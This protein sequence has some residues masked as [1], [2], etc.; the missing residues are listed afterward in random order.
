MTSVT[1]AALTGEPIENRG[2]Q[3]GNGGLGLTALVGEDDGYSQVHGN[4]AGNGT[5]EGTNVPEQPVPAAG[6]SIGEVGPCR[7]DHGKV[8]LVAIIVPDSAIDHV[9]AD[10]QADPTERCRDDQGITAGVESKSLP[11]DKISLA[12]DEQLAVGRTEG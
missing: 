2:T 10:G 12:V 3:D 7:R 5:G 11:E 6:L 4:L 8:D 9:G 1:D